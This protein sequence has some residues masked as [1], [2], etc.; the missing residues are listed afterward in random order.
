MPDNV[1]EV[2]E[3]FNKL[4]SSLEGKQALEMANRWKPIEDRLWKYFD[5]VLD[6][7]QMNGAKT[8]SQIYRLS[9]YQDLIKIAQDEISNFEKYANGSIADQQ[10]RSIDLGTQAALESLKGWKEIIEIPTFVNKLAVQNMVGVCADGKPL[11]SLLSNR[12]LDGASI[13]GLSQAL[14]E[15]VALGYNPKKTANM[16]ANGL[17]QGL[18]KALVIARTEQIRSYQEASRETYQNLGVTQYQRHCAFSDRTCLA[19]LG[20]DGQIVEVHEDF[21]SHPDCRCFSTPI[22]PGMEIRTGTGLVWFEK[23]SEEK[24][25]EILGTG[26][27]ELYKNGTNLFDMVSVK[28]DPVWGNTISIRSISELVE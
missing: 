27:Y 16:M 13:E 28:N 3:E 24:Q 10:R 2:M 21:S 1:Y 14:V 11:F 25:K 9:R 17:A 8:E 5:A 6:D 22:L 19:C 20:L 26:H 23:Q 7:I 18:S 4:L 12:K 15:G